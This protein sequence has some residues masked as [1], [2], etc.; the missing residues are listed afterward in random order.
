MKN[1][2]KL[3]I[4]LGVVTIARTKIGKESSSH[5]PHNSK[6]H[7]TETVD[8]I[9]SRAK[10][11]LQFISPDRLM[12]TP[13]CGLG[14]LTQDLATKKIKNIVAAAKLLNNP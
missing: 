9:A 13:D 5:S 3:G 6:P 7:L 12:L 14:F 1:L 4:Q 2:N 10:T 11:A 8:E